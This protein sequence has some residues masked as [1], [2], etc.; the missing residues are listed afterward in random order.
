QGRR[1]AVDQVITA[2]ADKQETGMSDL[3]EAAGSAAV[4]SATVT[5]VPPSDGQS[6]VLTARQLWSGAQVLAD[7]EIVTT[8]PGALLVAQALE[9]ALKA[10]LWAAGRVASSRRTRSPP[11]WSAS[12]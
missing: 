11:A 5:L 6:F 3:P 10:V 7:S 1:D 8:L 9:G 4:T 12:A 2:Q